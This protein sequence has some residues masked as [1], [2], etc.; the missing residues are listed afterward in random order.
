MVFVIGDGSGHR[1]HSGH[2]DTAEDDLDAG[3]SEVGVRIVRR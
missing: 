1:V 3:V 2:P